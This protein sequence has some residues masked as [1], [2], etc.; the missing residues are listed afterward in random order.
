MSG[1]RAS[2]GHNIIVACA[3]FA[4]V[5]GT[6]TYQAHHPLWQPHLQVDVATFHQR[7]VHFAQS[8]WAGMPYNEYQPGAL[9][10]FALIGTLVPDASS[11][12]GYRTGLIAAN[13]ALLVAHLFLY[14][15]FQRPYAPVIFVGLVLAAG[16]IVLYRFELLVSAL[17][18]A[19]W[20]VFRR[21]NLPAAGALLGL[22]SAVKLYPVI[23]LPV[24]IAEAIRKRQ[25]VHAAAVVEF[26]ILGA[27]VPT[28]AFIGAGGSISGILGSVEVHQLKPL[29]LSGLWTSLV[30]FWQKATGAALHVT[31]GYG[32]H[33]VTPTSPYLPLELFNWL[34][35]VPVGGVLLFLL[36]T[37]RRRGYTEPVI[38]FTLL[39]VFVLFSKVMNPQ[40][41]WWFIAFAPLLPL[42]T[43]KRTCSIG[44][45]GAGA[46]VLGLT[47]YIYPVRYTRFIEW[48]YTGDLLVPLIY[49]NASRLFLLGGMIALA[50]CIIW[51]MRGSASRDT[52]SP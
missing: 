7:A 10:F 4:V 42:R 47:Q 44:A 17:V 45:I 49:V 31:P 52:T 18:L 12:S 24:F 51:M 28:A 2:V 39:L 29:N 14:R 19:A 25:W 9:W 3:L 34:W 36:W 26:F 13:I 32:V 21:S 20:Y 27:L 6:L 33:G 30:L 43:R 15:A 22:A 40:Y 8:G 50:L 35:V 37:F 5:V 16:P 1:S 46:V 23:L 48:F 11:F 38:A 41:L